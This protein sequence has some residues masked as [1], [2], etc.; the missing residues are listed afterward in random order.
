MDCF[1]ISFLLLVLSKILYAVSA[2]GGYITLRDIARMNKVFFKAKRYGFTDSVITF[3][4]LLEQS[5]DQLF[6]HAVCTNRCL[7]HLLE[8]D[9]SLLQMSL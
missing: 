2:W 6:A 4:E 8:K 3:S 1:K 5:D 7:F 9:N